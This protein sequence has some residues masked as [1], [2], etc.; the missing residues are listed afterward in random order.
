ML[1]RPLR[2]AGGGKAR[3]QWYANPCTRILLWL[4][5]TAKWWSEKFLSNKTYF[6]DC[7]YLLWR[8]PPIEG[9]FLIQDRFAK[10]YS[11][12]V[13]L[14]SIQ[15]AWKMTLLRRTIS[16][17]IYSGPD[18]FTSGEL[19]SHFLSSSFSPLLIYHSLICSWQFITCCFWFMLVF[20]H[21]FPMIILWRTPMN[22]PSY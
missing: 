17:F 13:A 6:P 1:T 19:F 9:G 21:S 10:K 3:N 5:S 14:F 11:N 20:R 16:I 12:T 15:G 18:S 7:K 2:K 4:R 22:V 8:V